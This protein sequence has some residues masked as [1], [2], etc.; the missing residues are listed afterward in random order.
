LRDGEPSA[1]DELL[2][3]AAAVRRLRPDWRDA[4]AFYELRSEVVAAITRIARRLNG[5]HWPAPAARPIRP[6]AL[7][8]GPSH[9]QTAPP[10]VVIIQPPPPP[11]RMARRWARQRA[12]PRRHRYP[13]PPR[14]GHP[15]LL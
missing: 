1:A 8:A 2:G 5:H 12:R 15:I 7:A 9:Y 6:I 13:M 10:P 3:L 14:E 11:R 4:E